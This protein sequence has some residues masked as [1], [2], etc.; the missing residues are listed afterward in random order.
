[1]DLNTVNLLLTPFDESYLT[2]QYVGWLNDQE[3]MKYSEQRHKV[4]SVESCRSYW[5]SCQQNGSYFWAV[6][7]KNNGLKHIG[8]VTAYVDHDNSVA[9]VALLIGD[10][11]AHNKGYGFE[12]WECV[13]EYLL[14][15][16]KIRKITAGTLSLNVPM[17]KIMERLGMQDDGVRVNHYLVDNKPVDLI[18][19]SLFNKF[20]SYSCM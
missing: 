11:D 12:A 18:Y 6:V 4:H 20:D 1:M 10:Y 19:K 14:N 15:N 7:E 3:L 2:S 16:I 5:L 9:D 8:N 17:L 13:C